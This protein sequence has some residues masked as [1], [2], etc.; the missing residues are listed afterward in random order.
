MFPVRSLL[1]DL[2]GHLLER[3]PAH[4]VITVPR[5]TVLLDITAPTAARATMR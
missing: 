2:R 5:A 3:L 1:L 4:P